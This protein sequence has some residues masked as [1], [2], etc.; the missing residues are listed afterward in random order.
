MSPFQWILGLTNKVSKPAQAIKGDLNSLTQTSESLGLSWNKLRNLA[1]GALGFY[2]LTQA[3]D[4]LKDSA[5]ALDLE[6]TK[7][8]IQL[9][10]GKGAKQALDWID[11]ISGKLPIAREELIG[12]ADVAR[13]FNL[14]MSKLPVEGL[15]SS[16]LL[17]GNTVQGQIE[18]LTG[19]TQTMTMTYQDAVE[20]SINL[21][22]S[23][24][25]ANKILGAFNKT[26]WNS[27][28]RFEALADVIGKSVPDAIDIQS[29]SIEGLNQLMKNNFQVMKNAILGDPTKEGFLFEYKK[30]LQGMVTFLRENAETIKVIMTGVG[31]VITSIFTFFTDIIDSMVDRFKKATEGMTSNIKDFNK[32]IILPFV[33]FIEIIKVRLKAIIG[34]MFDGFIVGWGM[35]MK[36]IKP[37]LS[38]IKDA[39]VWILEKIGIINDEG[40][41]SLKFWHNLGIVLGIVVAALVV[42][43]I[44]AIA[45]SIASGILG[46]ALAVLTS[47]I[48]LIIASIAA[49]TA[50]IIW[51]HDNWTT[52]TKEMPVFAKVVEHVRDTLVSSWNTISSAFNRLIE[53][54]SAAWA[55]LSEAFGLATDK[56]ESKSIFF[57]ALEL[58]IKTLGVV[59]EY[60]INNI[61]MGIEILVSTITMLLDIFTSVVDGIIKLF[62][63][64]FSGAFSSFGDAIMRPIQFLQELWD[65]ITKFADSTIQSVLEIF[66]FSSDEN[67]EKTNII[68]VESTESSDVNAAV[69]GAVPSLNNSRMSSAILGSSD[70]F[71]PL[72]R[73]AQE[74]TIHNKI[75]MPDGRILAEVV[76]KENIKQG[77]RRGV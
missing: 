20:A 5:K 13:R 55:K 34:A 62:Q 66:S 64:D 76:N 60:T 54:L 65:T 18:T 22:G 11:T 67:E 44:A 53:P 43:K 8:Q 75:I 28:Q 24:K 74:L 69:A 58:V 23:T 51:L 61:V 27:T 3:V 25:N 45:A 68:S 41:S 9:G 52:V 57:T 32:N 40:E 59:F 72:G 35:T 49:L 15:Y 6:W 2:T 10:S 77:N 56:M 37:Y 7:L 19:M 26:A 33:T 71:A 46:G 70:D 42:F 29:E 50:G 21:T 17:T 36:V 1:M 73:T 39:F 14:N 38:F 47:P 12:L 16:A 4:T 48:T 30:S 31:K 63:G